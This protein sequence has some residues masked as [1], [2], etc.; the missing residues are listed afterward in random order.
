MLSPPRIAMAVQ[1]P[2]AEPF[3]GAPPGSC[4]NALALT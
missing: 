2:L 3:A 4:G 1:E